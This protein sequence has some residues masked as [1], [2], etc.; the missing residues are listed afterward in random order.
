MTAFELRAT[1]SRW[2]RCSR[3]GCSAC[4]S[5]L[6]VLALHARGRCRAAPARS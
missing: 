5:I 1:S 2:R 4:S 6:P 3:C